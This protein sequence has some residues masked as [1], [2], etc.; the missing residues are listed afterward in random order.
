MRSSADGL[1]VH[2]TIRDSTHHKA[3]QRS[4]TGIL[5]ASQNEIYIFDV[6]SLRFMHVTEGA[7]QNLG[8][9]MSEL[10]VEED[11]RLYRMRPRRR[12]PY[13]T[14][15]V[16]ALSSVRTQADETA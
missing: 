1:L 2:G 10:R 8:Y 14:L 4:L 5:Q 9:S 3:M 11:A 12:S 15:T 16:T 6:D 13:I 7:R